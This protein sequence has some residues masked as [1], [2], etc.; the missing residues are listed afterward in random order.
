MIRPTTVQAYSRPSRFPK[1][2]HR[3][4]RAVR[5]QK[6]PRAI[7]IA[8]TAIILDD[9]RNAWLNPS[10]LV[11][12]VTEVIPGYP[13]RVLPKDGASDVIL[14]ERTL[15]NLNNQRPQWLINAH[16]GGGSTCSGNEVAHHRRPQFKRRPSGID[17]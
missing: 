4:P 13:D 2:S 11:L 6:D 17:R 3:T 5:Y 15:T 8:S 10:D 7:G 14:R 16:A 1:A 9:L 12:I